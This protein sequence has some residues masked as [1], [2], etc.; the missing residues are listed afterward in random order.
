MSVD[1]R[2]IEFLWVRTTELMI[3]RGYEQFRVG[4]PQDI[5]D[6][7]ARGVRA[8]PL[9]AG[10]ALIS[11]IPNLSTR[12]KVI[13]FQSRVSRYRPRQLASLPRE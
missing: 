10:R 5:S 2:V 3:S 13:G 7:D 12:V 6:G 1:R 11:L 8:G 9:R 4:F